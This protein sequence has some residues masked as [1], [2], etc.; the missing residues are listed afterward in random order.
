[1][2]WRFILQFSDLSQEVIQEPKGWWDSTF[3]FKRDKDWHG[4]FFE[5]SLPLQ[6]YSEAYQII[7]TEYDTSGVEGN[8]KLIIEFACDDSDD[9]EEFYRAKLNF[10]KIKFLESENCL[11][12]IPIED[13]TDLSL[14]K[15][16]QDQEVDLE[17][18]ESLDGETLE[19]Y[20]FLDEEI[21][22]EPK[23]IFKH[24][25]SDITESVEVEKIHDPFTIGAGSACHEDVNR[26]SFFQ[27]GFNNVTLDELSTYFSPAIAWQAN[28]GDVEELFQASEAATYII[29]FDIRA[30][31]SLSLETNANDACGDCP[32]ND[33]DDIQH[34]EAKLVIV[35][36][37]TTYEYPKVNDLAC[38]S[39]LSYFL[40]WNTI[41]LGSITQAMAINDEI[42]VYIYVKTTGD[43]EE[44]L[45]ASSEITYTHKLNVT[46]G[47]SSFFRMSAL[48][49]APATPC[50][51]SLINEVLARTVESITNNKM[52]VY[53]EYF[54]RSD[55]EPYASYAGDGCG[56]L[57]AIATGLMIRQ[58]F[59]AKNVISF[60]KAF[61]ALNPIHN[62]GLGLEPDLVKGD[63]SL[64]VRIEPSRYFYEDNVVMTCPFVPDITRTVLTDEHYSIFNY[65]YAKW[66]AEEY[67]G[68][69]EFNT[70]R[71]S[72]TSL[73]S[74]KNTLSRISNFLA[75]GYAIEV[76]RGKQWGYTT[77]TDWRYDNEH[78]IICLLR[79]YGGGFIVEQG[80][81]VSPA[82]L[83]DPPTV[84]NFRISP[85]RNALRWL[86]K[87][88]AS[89]NNPA[90][91]DGMIFMSGEGNILAEGEL[92]DDCNV[93]ATVLSESE[94]VLDT[95]TLET[96]ADGLPIYELELWEFEYPMSVVEYRAVKAN[97]RGLIRVTY[98]Q[99]NGPVDCY[100]REIQYK[101]NEGKASFQL[102]PKFGF[103][104]GGDFDFNVMDFESADFYTN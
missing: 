33:P 38:N 6:F 88:L 46:A 30:L 99:G 31:L 1:M 85:N 91:S 70:K 73:K 57:E 29:D 13:D 47:G 37:V 32:G 96:S 90:S 75:S 59:A 40:N 35:A 87:T 103:S 62:I 93:E 8:L 60:K 27:F 98:G 5:Y 28:A 16:R 7:K 24:I 94:P 34:V 79:D 3:V 45:L 61:D 43:W 42:K 10:T 11:V 76:T 97:P 25:D 63:G 15:N 51:V 86:P 56:S 104:G 83:I 44:R 64:W 84:Y 72:R 80:N 66:E 26:E 39:G 68:L 22:L 71:S 95:S 2:R 17:S 54:G 14:F 36:G 58:Y 74:V 41:T 19:V 102:L 21:T 78:F 65:G 49:Y 18:L 4:I 55:S 81:I 92:N 69:D 101:P 82:N 53:S 9:F 12:E 48:T 89:Y 20:E 23:A 100:V 77:Q 50:R 52:T 67:T